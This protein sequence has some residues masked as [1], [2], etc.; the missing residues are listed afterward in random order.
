MKLL[1]INVDKIQ[2]FVTT[3]SVKIK[4]SVY[5]NA[6]SY[7]TE[8]CVI[9]DLFGILVIVNVSAINYVMLESIQIIKILNAEN[10]LVGKLVEGY[11]KAINENEMIYNDSENVC[12][13]CT[14]Y[15]VLFVIAFLKELRNYNRKLFLCPPQK[16]T[17]TQPA[18]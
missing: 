7:L 9:R 1:N 17:K 5:M 16:Q 14:V 11:S 18:F 13:S 12:N 3:N 6:K 8:E 15:M 10:K 2:F 4:A